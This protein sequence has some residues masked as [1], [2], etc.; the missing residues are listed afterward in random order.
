MFKI[1]AGTEKVFTAINRPAKGVE[2]K[3]I[4]QNL[5]SLK[6]ILIQSILVDGSPSNITDNELGAYF[7][8]LRHIRPT[9]VHLY[10]IDRPVPETKLKLVPPERLQAIAERGRKETGLDI[11][12]FYPR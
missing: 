5:Y 8:H 4:L 12:A 3:S 2:F 10:S 7:E 6:N 9:E 1:D 11:K